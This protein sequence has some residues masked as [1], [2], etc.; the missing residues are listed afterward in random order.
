MLLLNILDNIIGK[1]KPVQIKLNSEDLEKIRK[2]GEA[3][4]PNEC[5]GFLLGQSDNDIRTVVKIKPVVNT[6]EQ[7]KRYNRYLI[8]PEEYMR[9][10]RQASQ[11]GLEMI[12]VYHS[13]PDAEARPS[14][15]DL[16][17]SWPFYSYVIVSIKNRKAESITSWRLRDDRSA[18]DQEYIIED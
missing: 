10:E 4:Y 2:H 5:C 12:G 17:H 11:N 9:I 3:D 18:F 7:E 8:P 15:Y 14:E 6:R 13:H 16:E 1:R